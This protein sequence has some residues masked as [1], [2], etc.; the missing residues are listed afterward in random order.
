MDRRAFLA[1]AAGLP[2][3]LT[4]GRAWPAARGGTPLALVTADLESRVI[5]VH[6]GTGRI[7]GELATLAG[8]R[9][10]ESALGTTAVV[11]HT[12]EGAVSLV[13]GPRL[14]VRRVLD[15]FAAPRYTAVHPAGR[16]AYVTD[17]GRGDVA[18][19]DLDRGT[20]LRRVT[21]GGPAR[22]V[23]VAPGGARL[24]VALGSKALEVVQ[25]DIS[26]PSRPRA[27]GRLRPPYLAHDVAA[28]PDG[29]HVWVTSGDRRTIGIYDRP[30]GRLR[31]LLEAD[32]APQ[33]VTF[34]GGR[35]YV[36]SGDDGTLRVHL[37]DGRLLRRTAVPVGSYN[38]QQGWGV[39]LTPSLQRGTLAILGSDGRLRH[40]TPVARSSHDACFVV[41]A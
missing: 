8:P 13:D 40:T 30:T 6:L 7:H 16:L 19:L 3:A 22:H 26:E 32:A 27:A 2:F 34:I 11:A 39:V 38:V 33:H 41:A 31:R 20:V 23:T 28:T 36:A 21:V 9:S 24:W 5:A 12:T 14:R 1:A 15:G 18:V 4:A 10:I 35:A 29:S 25:L 17:S 37:L